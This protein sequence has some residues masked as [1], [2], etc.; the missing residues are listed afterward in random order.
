VKGRVLVAGFAT[1]HVV[2][3]AHRAGYETYAIDHFCD[4]DLCWYTKDHRIF[5]EMDELP[6]MIADLCKEKKIDILVVTSGAEDLITGVSVC[7]SKPECAGKFLDKLEI[8]KYFNELNIP[9]PPIAPDGEYPAMIKP[10]RGS[11]GWRNQIVHSAEEEAAW[12]ELRPEVPYIRQKPISGTPCSV[13]CVSNGK[14]ARAVAINEQILRGGEGEKSYGF[15]GAITPFSMKNKDFHQTVPDAG[16]SCTFSPE[17]SA[18]MIKTAEKAVSR[19]G[20]VGSVGVDFIINESAWAIE[21]NPRFQ[22]TLDT[23][24]MATGCSVFEMHVNACRGVIPDKMPVPKQYAVRKILFAERN[25]VA[26]TNLKDLA[27]LIADIPHVGT[28]IEE[29]CAVVSVYGTGAT[30][31]DALDMLDKI[32]RKMHRCMSRW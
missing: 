8:Q 4:Q 10:C 11:G 23:V 22:A 12:E 9:V 16:A 31:K 14:E 28:E 27:P 25:L 20:C 18:D 5:E 6:L 13:S 1:R 3:S 21:I 15:S 2:W 26:R 30:R 7:G 24:E 32:I 19:S 29:G 17:L